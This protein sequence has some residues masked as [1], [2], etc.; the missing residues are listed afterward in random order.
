M[1]V[2]INKLDSALFECT[3]AYWNNLMLNA[4]WSVGYVTTLIELEP[5]KQKEDWESFYYEL[6]E[7]RDRKINKLPLELQHKF[8]DEQLVLKD[9]SEIYTMIWNLKNLNFN[10][11]RTKEQIAKK[12]AILF[13]HT[14]ADRIRVSEE[15][16]VEA[17]RYRTVCQTWNGIMIREKNT[18]NTLKRTFPELNYVSTSGD[19]AHKYAVDYEVR[20]NERLICGIQIKPKSYLG[21]TPYLR[22]AQRANANKNQMYKD[23]FGKEVFNIIS[24]TNGEIL[25][26][27]A[28]KH[29]KKQLT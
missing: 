16:S 1:D 17:V 4:P 23:E 25:N 8:N 27:E 26:S 12:G 19:L 5:F 21:R 11:G 10:Y 24:K 14:Q 22:K 29:L 20:K 9:K 2:F 3:N 6:G 28:I 13:K 15:D 7:E 18:I